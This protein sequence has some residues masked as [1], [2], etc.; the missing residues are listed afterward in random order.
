MI[1]EASRRPRDVRPAQGNDVPPLT[2]HE[3]VRGVP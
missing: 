1:D 3:V 2:M